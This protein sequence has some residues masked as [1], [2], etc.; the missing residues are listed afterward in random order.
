[1]FGASDGRRYDLLAGPDE[2]VGVTVAVWTAHPDAVGTVDAA[3]VE[4][5]ADYFDRAEEADAAALCAAAPVSETA[6]A[7]A[8]D[9][10]F[11]LLDAADLADRLAALSVRHDEV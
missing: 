9:T 8:A 10:G 3:T 6:S 5:Y 1:V 4:R 11:E 2:P 7:R